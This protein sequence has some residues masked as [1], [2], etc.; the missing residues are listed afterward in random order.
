MFNH[1]LVTAIFSAAIANVSASLI[2]STALFHRR[3]LN[4]IQNNIQRRQTIPLSVIPIE[5]QSACSPAINAVNTCQTSICICTQAVDS[6]AQECIDCV[7]QS[8]E[9]ADFVSAA[10][11]VVAYYNRECAGT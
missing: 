1:F 2:G 6:S 3:L 9:G 8:P 7:L 10:E 11:Q 5:C 4:G